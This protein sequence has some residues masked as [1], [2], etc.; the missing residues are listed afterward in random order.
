MIPVKHDNLRPVLATLIGTRAEGLL[1]FHD[2]H[3][4]EI[5]VAKGSGHNHQA[6]SGG[7]HDH[8]FHCFVLAQDLYRLLNERIGPGPFQPQNVAGYDDFRGI[9]FSLE[10]AIIVLYLHDIE[11]IFKY[12]LN[13]G[14]YPE[15]LIEAKDAWYLGI[16]PEKYGVWLDDQEYNALKYAHGEGDDHRKDMRVATPLAGFIHSIDNLSARVLHNIREISHG[17]APVVPTSGG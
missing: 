3:I 5:L 17:F 4:N 8:L 1:R 16:L 12:G 15:R 9:P 7:Y 13:P 6:W 2:D 14:R 10:S 11:K